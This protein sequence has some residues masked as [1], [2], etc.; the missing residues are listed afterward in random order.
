MRTL[1]NESNL[2]DELLCQRHWISLKSAVNCRN[3]HFH[4]ENETSFVEANI[5][6]T[7]ISIACLLSNPYEKCRLCT[8]NLRLRLKLHANAKNYSQN[9]KSL[10]SGNSSIKGKNRINTLRKCNMQISQIFSAAN[11]TKNSR[12]KFY[13]VCVW[14]CVWPIM[15]VSFFF[16]LRKAVERNVFGCGMITFTDS[17]HSLFS[18]QRGGYEWHCSCNVFIA[19]TKTR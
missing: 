17:I 15:A 10:L 5:E 14:W 19:A 13:W 7:M 12:W 9:K 3:S 2:S 1:S 16:F 8:F 6:F 4:H 18:C 11:S